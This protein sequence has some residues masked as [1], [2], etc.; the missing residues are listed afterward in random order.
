MTAVATPTTGGSEKT[1]ARAGQ[2]GLALVPAA[3]VVTAA[4]FVGSFAGHPERLGAAYQP[5]MNA[6]VLLRG[7]GMFLSVVIVWGALRSRGS[8]R[9]VL[10]LAILSGPVAYGVVAA[11]GMLDYFPPGQAAYYGINPIFL[12][13][14]GGQCAVAA[15][16]EMI[17]RWRSRRRGQYRGRPVTWWLVL[18]FAL[19]VGVVFG[20]VLYDGGVPFFYVYQRGYLLLFT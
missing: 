4:A 3:I 20:T 6:G 17:W 13:A 11:I 16:A 8:S 2:V 18:V 19:G 14:I 1:G 10:A 12:A 5:L 15:V 9:P 7:F